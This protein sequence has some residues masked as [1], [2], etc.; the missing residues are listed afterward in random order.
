MLTIEFFEKRAEKLLQEWD[1]IND[2]YGLPPEEFQKAV[3]KVNEATT[4]ISV[5]NA[6][7][8]KVETVKNDLVS[9]MIE[10]GVQC[11]ITT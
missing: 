8:R 1:A 9:T 2:P 4:I 5:L 11:S 10:K 3:H 6:H 7:Y